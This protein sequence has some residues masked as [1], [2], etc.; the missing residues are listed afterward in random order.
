MSLAFFSYLEVS[1]PLLVILKLVSHFNSLK[2]SEP[3][4]PIFLMSHSFFCFRE[5]AWVQALLEPAHKRR[6]M[7]TEAKAKVVAPFWGVKFI[8]FLAALA[9]LPR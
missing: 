3:F 4:F 1:E 2:A 9:V 7:E 5:S 8:K 6:R